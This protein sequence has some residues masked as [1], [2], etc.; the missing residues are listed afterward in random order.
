[1]FYK[2]TARDCSFVIFLPL[3][4]PNN[5]YEVKI[6]Y[7]IIEYCHFLTTL[8]IIL[9]ILLFPYYIQL[10]FDFLSINALTAMSHI[11]AI[12]FSPKSIITYISMFMSRV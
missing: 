12:R 2:L 10:L 8:F 5:F 3:R 6:A 1:M 4:T 7:L 11:N 9:R